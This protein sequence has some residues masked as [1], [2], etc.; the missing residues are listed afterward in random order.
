MNIII[1]KMLKPVLNVENIS[2]SQEENI[3]KLLKNIIVVMIARIMQSPNISERTGIIRITMKIIMNPKMKSL[4]TI[5][6][7]V[8]SESMKRK[9]FQKRL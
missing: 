8:L 4:I 6:G 7:T 3:Q 9:Q 5:N 2:L 1:L